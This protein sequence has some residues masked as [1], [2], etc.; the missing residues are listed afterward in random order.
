MQFNPVYLYSNKVDVFTNLDS[1]TTERYRKVYQRNFKIYRGIDNRIDLQVRNSDEKAKDITG[2]TLVFNLVE[3]GSQKLVLTKD[4]SIVSAV[5][6][7]FFVTL[8][9]VEMND[10]T[11]GFYDFSVYT[12]S[13]SGARHLLYTDSQFGATGSIE[14]FGDIAGEP[15]ESTVIDTFNPIPTYWPNDGTSRSE[16]VYS[17]PEFSSS[18]TI[19]TFAVYNSTYLGTIEIQASLEISS[20]PSAGQ[21]VSLATIINPENPVQYINVEGKWNWFRIKHTPDE[22]NLGTVDKVLYR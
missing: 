8:T 17:S 13:T 16:L 21:W 14:V 19:H 2:Y 5:N 9:E 3:R 22:E 18:N 10:L 7:K 6:G 20:A 4:C 1:W 12:V 11:K 15:K